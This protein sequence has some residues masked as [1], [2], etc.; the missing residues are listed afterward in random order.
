M[1]M[2][3]LYLCSIW[4]V[5]AMSQDFA[6]QG[7]TF[8]YG[9]GRG[10]PYYI[11]VMEGDTI[12]GKATRRFVD[13]D[14]YY[15]DNFL[16][17]VDEIAFYNDGSQV[18]FFSPF[19][20]T[21]NLLYDFSLNENDTLIIEGLGRTPLNGTYVGRINKVYTDTICGQSRKVWELEDLPPIRGEEPR[22]SFKGSIIEGLGG[23]NFL[24]PES[25]LIDY[26]DTL[27]CVSDALST[28]KLVEYGCDTLLSSTS[29]LERDQ[30]G[31]LCKDRVQEIM[32]GSKIDDDII[33][34]DWMVDVYDLN[35]RCV[36]SGTIQSI[37]GA[38]HLVRQGLYIVCLRSEDGDLKCVS[39]YYMNSN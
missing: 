33:N 26:F 9:E 21:F 18:Y 37:Y 23:A 13:E 14:G 34:S 24:F 15:F 11:H 2:L 30:L 29:P 10:R 6:P 8:T 7:T 16:G 27:R 12:N 31:G 22:L 38:K 19:T 1:R 36:S 28:C 39:K 17:N 5:M 32:G 3:I 25:R 35:G 4:S 20:N